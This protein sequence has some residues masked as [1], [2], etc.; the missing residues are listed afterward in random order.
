MTELNDK[1]ITYGNLSTFYDKLQEQGLG[2][3][4]IEEVSELPE[5]SDNK[6]KLFRLNNGEKD[7][8]AAKLLFSETTTT[9]RLPDE[10]QIDKA[11][12]YLAD[13]EPFYYKGTWKLILNNGEING[14]GWLE[15]YPDSDNW[16]LSFT[17]D[18][19]VNTTGE[20]KCYFL[21]YD[22]VNDFDLE[23]HTVTMDNDI[24]DYS[25]EYA[26]DIDN[27]EMVPIPATY[28]APESAQIG[29]AYMDD[30]ETYYYTGVQKTIVC[31]DGSLNLY[32]WGDNNVY[33][34]FTEKQASELYLI[35]DADE[36]IIYTDFNVAYVTL[37]DGWEVSGNTYTNLN[38]STEDIWDTVNSYGINPIY[39]PQLNALDSEQVGNAYLEMETHDRGNGKFYYKGEI[40]IR[41]YNFET[42]S[43]D[44][45]IG[46]L[47]ETEEQ[48]HH[49][50]VTLTNAQ[51]V[52]GG[53]IGG[54]FA[55]EDLQ[56]YGDEIGWAS[57]TYTLA[58]IPGLIS[59]YDSEVIVSQVP[60]TVKYQRTEITEEWDWQQ[61]TDNATNDDI[62]LMFFSSEIKLIRY[63]DA[64]QQA[65]GYVDMW[66][67]TSGETMEYDG[68]TYYKWVSWANNGGAEPAVENPDFVML[69]NTLDISLPFNV[70]SPE[71]EYTITYNSEEGT[72][73][74][75][76]V[77][78]KGD[79]TQKIVPYEE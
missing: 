36:G 42:V 57:T 55:D 28:N 29:N 65:E 53:N 9:N 59:Y 70:D 1:L 76:G 48:Y 60:S 56:N 27:S 47:W 17:Q 52:Y 78:F 16:Y 51:N 26:N 22:E 24:A 73:G 18:D 23:N 79:Y 44:Y 69:T 68:N 30:G 75:D 50:Y 33:F 5:A 25:W 64:E 32:Q 58:E 39:I 34:Y 62:D 4:A 63:Q 43:S 41:E 6:D 10:Q 20:T 72:W 74:G 8:Y 3:A 14:Y 61:L 67:N 19:A 21:G 15:T 35:S 2:G 66:V 12:L 38:M 37:E 31:S 46:H 77:Y 71:Y 7:V 40:Q 11:Y 54:H 49:Y 45:V 13:D